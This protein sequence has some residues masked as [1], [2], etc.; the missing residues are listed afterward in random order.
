M[1]KR[2]YIIVLLFIIAGIQSAWSQK[3]V[4][5]LEGN[6]KIEY[7]VARLDSIT[8]IEEES[9]E[10]GDNT[11][12]SVTDD[13]IDITNNSATLVGYATSIRDNLSTDLRVGFI[14][15][16]EGTPSKNNGTQVDVSTND[17]AEDGR[18]TKTINNLLS[19][20]TYY[21]RSFVYQSG[22]WFYGKVKS[23]TTKGIDVYF[24]TGAATAITCF[25]AKVS[26]SVAVEPPHSSLTYGICYGTNIEPS[27]SDNIVTA[28]PNTFTLQLRKLTGGTTYY[29]RPY[30]IVDDQTYYGTIRTFRTLDDNVVETGSIDE[31]TLTITSHFT[32]GGGDY[33]SL[34][35]GVCYGKTEVPTINDKTVITKEVDNDNN[36]TVELVSPGMDTIYYRSFILIDGIAHYGDI[37]RF[38]PKI[39]TCAR[40][41]EITNAMN[42]GA[43]S[44]ENYTLTGYITDVVGR[45]DKNQQSFWMADTK[46]GGHVFYSFWANLPEGV[47]QFVAGTKIKLTGQLMK[48][49]KNGE[50]TP[51]MKNGNVEILDE[52]EGGG[53]GGEQGGSEYSIDLSYTG[54][55]NFYDNGVATINGEADCKVLKIGTSKAAGDFTLSVPAG[56]HSFY[57]VTWKGAGTA[58]VILK[59]GEEVIKTITV[60]ENDGATQNSPYTITVTSA[61]KYEF[62][63]ATACD[64]TVTSDKRIIFFGI[65]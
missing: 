8:F 20:A 25:S 7:N 10:I 62:E 26:F 1:N 21:Y 6:Q 38:V 56:K 47:S 30:A 22:I 36:Y 13:A 48:Y 9:S 42:D 51:E 18:Y 52:V 39:V 43:T 59:K 5:H 40:A 32:I 24:T 50:V 19:D 44:K 54:G 53:Q 64:V 29:Y 49:V 4:L 16:L 15:S 2:Y 57:A 35:L 33:S 17:V 63:V 46:D 58:D 60:K 27:I 3:I 55:A 14:Y 65:K 61:D 23:F 41:V 12:P 28:F 11:D 45:V 31:E 34:V 37:K